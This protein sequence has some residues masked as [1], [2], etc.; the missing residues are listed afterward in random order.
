MRRVFKHLKSVGNY[1]L[2]LIA[3]NESTHERMAVYQSIENGRIWARPELEFFDG[4]F[5]E[6]S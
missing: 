2:L 1:E 6:E 4:R 3:T 5:K